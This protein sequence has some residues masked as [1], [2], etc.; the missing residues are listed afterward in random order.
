MYNFLESA[1]LNFVSFNRLRER[2]KFDIES[3]HLDAVQQK[4]MLMLTKMDQHAI[5]EIIHGSINGHSFYFSKQQDSTA[6]L[7]DDVIPFLFGS[8][9]GL[10]ESLKK[11]E[12]TRQQPIF[13]SSCSFEK[14]EFH[15][16][17]TLTE[18]LKHI[19]KYLFNNKNLTLG[20]MSSLISES[21]GVSEENVKE[22]FKQFY[23]SASKHG[24]LLLTNKT[25]GGEL[26]GSSRGL[27]LF[28]CS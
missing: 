3:L 7:Q 16:E 19:F 4:E 9:V 5:A 23:S 15:L 20:E 18:T 6:E 27:H 25:T 14:T 11:Y 10:Q 26:T 13:R 1:G 12:D 28:F 2:Q 17:F 8:P 21:C 22:E 24:L